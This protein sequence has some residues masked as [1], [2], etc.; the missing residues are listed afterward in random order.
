MKKLLCAAFAL[1]TWTLP[2]LGAYV[3]LDDALQAHA[4]NPE[5]TKTE[6]ALN[7]VEITNKSPTETVK[8]KA[9]LPLDSTIF[10]LRDIGEG[11]S[12]DDI[13]IELGNTTVRCVTTVLSEESVRMQCGTPELHFDVI[14][15]GKELKV[16]LIRMK[17]AP[18]EKPKM[19]A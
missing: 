14:R 16:Y 17:R 5:Q 2:I 12:T 11:V 7:W 13:A 19:K 6:L 8:Q 10:F 4:G 1:Y 18:T 15:A 3:G 9:A